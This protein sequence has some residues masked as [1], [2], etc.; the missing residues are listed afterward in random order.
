VQILYPEYDFIFLFDHSQ[1]QARNRGGALNA[2]HMSRTYDGA[3]PVLRNRIMLE[4]EGYLGTNLPRLLNV[5][6]SQ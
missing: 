4:E 2:A 3:Q 6:L 5:T 1:G